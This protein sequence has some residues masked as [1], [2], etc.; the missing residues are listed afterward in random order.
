M[1]RHGLSNIQILILLILWAGPAAA[2]GKLEFEA[3]IDTEIAGGE[4]LVLSESFIHPAGDKLHEQKTFTIPPEVQKT[5]VA[6]FICVTGESG[7]LSDTISPAVI[8]VKTRMVSRYRKRSLE[9]LYHNVYA[10]DPRETSSVTVS[11]L[12]SDVVNPTGQLKFSTAAA[13][14]F[15]VYTKAAAGAEMRRIRLFAGLNNPTPGDVYAFN[16]PRKEKWHPVRLTVGG[17]HGIK[18]NATGNLMNGITLSGGDDWNGSTGIL[19]DVDKYQL[20]KWKFDG[21][22]YQYAIDTI[23][24]WIYPEFVL[25]EEEAR[26]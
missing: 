7:R 16:F 15:V 8:S 25:F 3:M 13:T 12:L 24:N 22:I 6:G 17:G 9:V 23:L 4:V 10:F 5:A 26:P 2:E 21:M 20:K 11:N 18:G 14:V 1:V 19:W